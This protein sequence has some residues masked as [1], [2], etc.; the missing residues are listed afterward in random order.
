MCQAQPDKT[1]GEGAAMPKTL[2]PEH[3]ALQC[4][5]CGKRQEA[6]RKLINGRGA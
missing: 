2:L 5:F 6:V 3:P 1:V 4:S